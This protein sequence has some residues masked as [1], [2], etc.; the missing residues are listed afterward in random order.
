M[1]IIPVAILL[2][3]FGC[4]FTRGQD[5]GTLTIRQPAVVHG[6]PFNRNGCLLSAGLVE[7]HRDARCTPLLSRAANAFA[8][9]SVLH[10][11][12]VGT[13]LLVVLCGSFVYWR[14]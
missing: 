5:A 6:S 10:V 13:V 11:V 12:Y 9:M 14:A 8:V 1:N 3:T 2:V 4:L 7:R